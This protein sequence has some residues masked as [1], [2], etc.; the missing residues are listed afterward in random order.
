ML[1]SNRTMCVYLFYCRASVKTGLSF[2]AVR[3]SDSALWD[4]VAE[5]GRGATISVV[6]QRK[7]AITAKRSVHCMCT[8]REVG[9]FSP[10]PFK[11]S[12]STLKQPLYSVTPSP[13]LSY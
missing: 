10:E 11:C 1:G 8:S 6:C 13:S 5:P 3:P 7:V 2:S 12:F 4:I 9:V